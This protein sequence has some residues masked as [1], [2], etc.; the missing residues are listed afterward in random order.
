M[1]IVNTNEKPQLPGIY[2]KEKLDKMGLAVK[3]FAIKT[4]KPEKTIHAVING[5]SSITPEMAVLFEQILDTPASFLLS[6]QNSYDTYLAQQK[7][8]EHKKS[9]YEWARLFPYG[10]M[11]K[12]GYLPETSKIEER[13]KYLLQFFNIA[14]VSAWEELYL[15]QGFKV[16]FRTSLS[17]EHRAHAVSAWLRKGE[18]EAKLMQAQK[19]DSKKFEHQLSLCKEIMVM[20]PVDFFNQ[21]QAACLLVGVK[22]IFTQAIKKAPITGAT[23]WV[24]EHPII[25]LSGYKKTYDGLWFTFF[26]EAGHILLHGKRDV[27]LEDVSYTDFDQEKEDEANDFAK[28]WVCPSK[29]FNEFINENDYSTTAIIAF[30]QKVNTHPSCVLGQLRKNELLDYYAHPL[31]VKLKFDE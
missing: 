14:T 8:E 19:F 22:V 13:T 23:R 28:E 1:K 24:G 9:F 26:H 25:Q 15:N 30:A 27:F 16:Q 2:L 4:G 20:N 21:V 5:S 31:D 29:E 11:M 7:Y 3:E 6:I 18:I 10:D 17:N 12:K